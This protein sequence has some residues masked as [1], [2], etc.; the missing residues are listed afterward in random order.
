MDP[1]AAEVARLVGALHG[2]L[3]CR[4]WPRGPGSR[5]RGPRGAQ[6]SGRVHDVKLRFPQRAEHRSFRPATAARTAAA[7]APSPAPD[8]V[9]N[10]STPP[11]A[12]TP[13]VP[14]PPGL[15]PI[16]AWL[17]EARDALT[18]ND[19]FMQVAVE[20]MRLCPFALPARRAGTTA[21]FVLPVCGDAPLRAA[22]VQAIFHML[23]ASSRLEVVQ[24]ICPRVTLEPGAW[25]RH[26]KEVTAERAAGLHGSAP[27][28]SAAFHPDLPFSDGSAAR[29]IP[30]FRRSPDPMLQLIRLDALDRARVGR[31][32]GD[33]ALP[34]DLDARRAI[35]V[36][37]A[38]PS[39]GDSIAA[40]NERTARAVGVEAL[41]GALAAL[42]PRR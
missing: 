18:R 24:I 27:V 32:D 35:L 5:P 41:A 23:S 38:R 10:R 31:P 42:R 4:S 22:A 16:D 8:P 28:A 13:G 37:H 17:S 11:C 3:S 14:G 7:D 25:V 9:L 36:S 39:L 19:R 26:A 29:L 15:D 40:A 12:G 21:R 2:S 1:L 30:L 20:G 33:I 34:D 6:N